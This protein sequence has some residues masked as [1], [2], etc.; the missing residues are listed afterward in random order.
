MTS[1]AN[2]IPIVKMPDPVLRQI[3]QPVAEITDGVRQ[4]LDLGYLLKKW[5]PPWISQ[6]TTM[7]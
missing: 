2:L 7:A 4:P 6:V 3:A 5:W 1:T